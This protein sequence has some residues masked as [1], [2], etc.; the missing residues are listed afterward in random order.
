MRHGC[1]SAVA[2]HSKR[3][4]DRPNTCLPRFEALDNLPGALSPIALLAE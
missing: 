2:S 1:Q 4:N 3:E